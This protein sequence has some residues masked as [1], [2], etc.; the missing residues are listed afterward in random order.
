MILDFRYSLFNNYLIVSYH[1]FLFLFLNSDHFLEFLF[2]LHSLLKFFLFVPS[3]PQIFEFRF[4]RIYLIY[5]FTLNGI[6][7]DDNALNNGIISFSFRE[8][9]LNFIVRNSSWYFDSIMI[10]PIT[11]NF[12]FNIL[13]MSCISLSSLLNHIKIFSNNF[14]S[15]LN[16]EHSLSRLCEIHLNQLIKTSANFMIIVFFPFFTGKL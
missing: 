10:N 5:F 1:N 6:I 3:F 11:L 7:V 12:N 13:F 14:T 8:S 15:N 2:F 16:I 9:E 4:R